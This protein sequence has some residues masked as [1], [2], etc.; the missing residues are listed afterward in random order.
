MPS[1]T[2]IAE[3]GMI[4]HGLGDPWGG[5]MI[6]KNSPQKR[7]HDCEN[8]WDH[9]SE[10]PCPKWDHVSEKS[11]KARGKGN[12]VIK[13]YLSVSGRFTTSTT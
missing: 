1:L 5:I 9:V 10:N 2:S 4:S 11:Q 7:D 6:L 13:P 12:L 3:V 8:G